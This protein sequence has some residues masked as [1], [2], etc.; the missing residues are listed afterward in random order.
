MSYTV[1]LLSLLGSVIL[2]SI[3]VFLFT[4]K[5]K[6][7]SKYIN[8]FA[9]AVVA[10]LIFVHIL[11]EIYEQKSFWIGFA[12]MIG[13]IFQLVLEKI[14]K[15]IE[16]GHVHSHSVNHKSILW[17]LMIGLGIHSLVEGA[18]I[19]MSSEELS[20]TELHHHMDVDGHD[21]NHEGHSH[22]V[23][24][25]S[26]S[27]ESTFVTAIL[28]H[29]VPVTIVLSLFLLSVGV[30]KMRFFGFILLFAIMTPLGGLLGKLL[31]N[32]KDVD[33]YTG[34]FMAFSTGMLLHIITAILFEH[35]HTKK[36]SD[37]HI[38][39]ITLGVTLGTLIFY[40]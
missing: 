35:S 28:F 25:K 16:H 3:L 9:A 11:P 20:T 36:E 18:P 21:H 26:K 5:I 13:M 8:T 1:T 6:S 4:D 27:R 40:F 33:V 30:K 7:R 29:K 14:T 15:G 12:L 23:A 22:E 39:I 38:L 24:G 32:V 10:A 19:F 34:Y 31:T 17:G 37:A 2:T